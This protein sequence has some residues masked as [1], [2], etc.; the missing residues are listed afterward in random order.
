MREPTREGG[1]LD[2]LFPNIEALVGDVVVRGC[3][4]HSSHEMT[5]F[6]PGRVM[7]RSAEI[8]LW[9]SRGKTSPCLGDLFRSLLGGSPEG[10]RS[11]GNLN[12]L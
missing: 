11:S 4:L 9:T 12:T 5:V 1:P 2:Q 3:I 10:Q 7:K 8:P 6:N